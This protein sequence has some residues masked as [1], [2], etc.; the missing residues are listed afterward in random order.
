MTQLR[1]LAAIIFTDIVGYT[2]LMGEDEQKAFELLRI[3][4]QI[5]QPLVKKYN[6]SWIKEIGDGVLASFLTVT[7]AVLCATEIQKA[8]ID[9]KDLKLRI[10][11]HQGEVVFE[12]NDVFGDGV[13]IA[14]RLQ[15]LAPVGGI[16]VSE[17]VYKNISNKKE[18]RTKFISEEVLKNVKEPVRIYEIFIHN[19]E[20]ER[21]VIISQKLTTKISE[22]SIAVLPF[23]NMSSDP[24]QEFFS[25]GLTE[26][27][28]TDLS[29]LEKLLVISRSSIMTFKGTHKKIKEIANEVNVRYILEGSIRKSGNNLRITAQLIDAFTD[30]HLWAEKYS[31]TMEDVFDIQEKVSRSI[32]EALD[33]KLTN[34]ENSQ[35]AKHPIQNV[36]AYE[37][38]IR[39]RQEM[40][41]FTEQGLGN[42]IL[43]AQR[44]LDI[45]GDNAFLLATLGMAYYCS[46]HYAIKL[47]PS[48]LD[49]AGQYASRSLMLDADCY[50]GQ[51]LK[52]VIEMKAGNLQAA[53]KIL[54]SVLSSDPNN[55]DA[56]GFLVPIYFLVGRRDAAKLYSEKL[57]QVDPL[58]SFTYSYPGFIEWYSGNIKESLPY[59]QKWLELD[60]YGPFT[61]YFCSVNYFLNN[62]VGASIQILNS[63]IEETPALIFAKFALFLKSAMRGDK[64]SALKYAT[65]ELQSGAALIDYFTLYMAYAYAL[66]DEKEETLKWL[67]KMLFRFGQCPYPLLLKMEIFHQ[68][69]KDHDGFPVFMKEAKKRSE[70]FDA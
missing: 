41:K 25:D 27:I 16:W 55:P 57:L 19:N 11:I 39:A 53:C 70:E 68:V 66:I 64:V 45:V 21:P 6:G 5:Q 60:P 7:E 43:I 37:C 49:K 17:S 47:D 2:S 44:G 4:R 42:A 34:Q 3:N 1:Q 46:Y 30:V 28:I 51:M 38:Y 67:N 59:F 20:T 18:I 33:L 13:N 15:A 54:K 31:G 23:V 36:Q 40:Y 65:E 61:R 12:D 22:K 14:A 29:R 52:G 50:Q 9:M 26:E 58:T 35:L 48:Y 69:L 63:I 24:E 10:G 62:E 32:V 8:C 56:L